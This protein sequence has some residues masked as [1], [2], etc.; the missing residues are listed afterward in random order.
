M[1]MTV[2]WEKTS[3]PINVS[4]YKH[5]VISP[6]RRLLQSGEDVSDIAQDA[7]G[8]INSDLILLEEYLLLRKVKFESEGTVIVVDNVYEQVTYCEEKSEKRQLETTVVVEGDNEA[9]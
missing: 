1:Q 9:L 3:S 6:F 5:V 2:G 8:S 7:A 4:W